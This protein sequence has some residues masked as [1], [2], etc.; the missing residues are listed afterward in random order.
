ML[1]YY[2]VIIVSFPLIIY[3]IV[4][5][6][7]LFRHP[8]KYDEYYC[9]R[10]ARN[11]VKTVMRNARIKT[12]YRGIEN[13]PTEGGYILYPN[14][15]GK[16]DA[17][18]II[19]AL[20]EPCSIVIDKNTAKG[21]LTNEF[22]GLLNGI[23]LDKEDIN[24]QLYS[25][26]YMSEEVKKGRRYILFAEGGYTDNRNTLQLF[27]PGAF[28]AALW[29]KCPIVPVALIDSYKPFSVSSLKKVTTKVHFLEPI[30]YEDYKELNT[31]QIAT[32]VREKIEDDIAKALSGG[33]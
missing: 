6:R 20:D 30:E 31:R 5:A 24:Q 17:L 15:Q 12:I 25:I 3:Y 32:L 1:R 33:K 23:R 4:K 21:A 14:H 19:N 7:Y 29:A 8:D 10:V 27:M 26:K 28:K 9:Y 22:T 2:F 16:Y 13:L 18:G 11:M